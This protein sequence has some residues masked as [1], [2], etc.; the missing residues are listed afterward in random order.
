MQSPSTLH[1]IKMYGPEP[2]SSPDSIHGTGEVSE[3][4]AGMGMGAL[5]STSP[6]SQPSVYLLG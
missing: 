6:S 2:L 3:A 1:D 5:A 4:S